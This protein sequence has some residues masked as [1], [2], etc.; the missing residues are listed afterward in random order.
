MV[1]GSLSKTRGRQDQNSAKFYYEEEDWD[2]DSW[3]NV[4]SIEYDS[5]IE[6]YPFNEKL[7]S[8]SRNEVVKVLDIGCG[9]AIFPTFLDRAL[10]HNFQLECDLLDLSGSSLRTA[11]QVLSGLDHFSVNRVYQSLIEDI[12]TNLSK[13]KAQYDLIW[14]IHSFTTVEID[15]MKDVYVHLL[16]MLAPNGCIFVYQ[17]TSSSTYQKLHSY[18]LA[19]HSNGKNSLPFMEYEDSKKILDSIEAKYEVHELYFNHEI[20]EQRTDLLDK[21]LRKCILDDSVNVLE[22]FKPILEAFHDERTNLYR[23]P[24]SVNFIVISK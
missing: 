13:N 19:H 1:K 12:P 4:I 7:L 23:F 10:T 8:I 15:K 6:N 24:Q 3:L 5:L 21:Y 20:P 2:L 14:A 16:E 17:L 22:F 9:T 11:S 18:Y